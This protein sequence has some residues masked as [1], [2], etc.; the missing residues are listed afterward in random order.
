MM[1]NPLLQFEN[2]L[3]AFSQIL[4]EHIQPALDTV[5][6]ENRAQIAVLL[7]NTQPFTGDNLLLP[8]EELDAHLHA[9][10]S[11]IAH[12]HAVLSSESLRAEYHACLPK[13]AE[14]STELG[15]NAQLYAA[16]KSLAESTE[17]N[18]LHYAQQKA[19]RD[20]LREF[21]LSGVALEPA[22]KQRYGEL[23]KE[24]AL[25]TSQFEDNVLDA[26]DGWI[27]HVLDKSHLSGLPD[28]ALASAQAEAQ[29]RKLDGWVF[30]LEFPSYVAIMSCAD[31]PE[32]RQQI[33]T[34]YVTRASD[35]GPQAG[36]W[37]NSEVMEKI[38][39]LR[40]ELAQL[41]G[42][43]HYTELSLATKMAKTTQQV[44]GFLN[45]LAKRSHDLAVA[46]LEEL[47]Q[48]SQQHY[49]ISKLQAW[50]ISYYSEKLKHYRYEISQEMLRDYF[51]TDRVLHGLFTI[52][53]RLFG[54]HVIEISGVDT[55]HKDVRFFEVYDQQNNL[56]GKFYLDLYARPH[57]RSGA[58]MDESRARRRDKNGNIQ[59]P[60]AY[61]I[62]N[63]SPPTETQPALFTHEEVV[64]LFHEFGHGLHHLLTRVDY[65]SVSG[66]NG[67][68]WD[69]VE[70]PSQMLENWCW[71]KEAI[72]LISGHY[73]TGE[74]LPEE[75]FRRMLA[76]KNFQAA[77][78]M[79]RQLEFALFDFRLHMEYDPVKGAQIQKILDEVRHAV[80]VIPIT[81]FNRFQHSFNHIFSGGY[82]AGYYSYKWSEVLASDAYAKFEET[83]IFNTQ[84]GKQFLEAI[85]EQGGSREPME[86]FIAFRGREPTIDALL[87]HC[88]LA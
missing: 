66:I 71:E 27:C 42:F 34:A 49:G 9:T 45:G 32:L 67:I 63:F 75:L 61:L 17:F 76:A 56:R 38:I 50:D 58:W 16:F 64:T 88:G 31:S 85:L 18:Q 28:H 25:L 2:E 37:D 81:A 21:K 70:F 13:L 53:K 78:H 23:Q 77:M 52:V 47:Q 41:L 20:A 1:T 72:D 55:W 60:I 8:L 84:T 86:L 40:H 11:P 48:F 44:L 30:T 39:K 24:L 12:L 6:A 10:W 7:S 35:Q 36:Q 54:I 4:P 3:P 19:I 79:A 43:N 33:Y 46:D 15:Q 22:A 51:P 29:L 62:C 68:P 73:Q 14:Y 69:A 80:A 59:T 82:A 74:P 5:L 87:R 57:K 83:G 26:T 65:A